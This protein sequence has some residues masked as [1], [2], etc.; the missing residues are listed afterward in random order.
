MNLMEEKNKNFL[1]MY[2]M[3]VLQELRG[4]LLKLELTISELIV[5]IWLNI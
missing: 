2:N 1:F 5:D 3:C 4:E